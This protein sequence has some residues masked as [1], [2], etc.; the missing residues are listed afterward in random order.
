MYQL[1]IVAISV[2]SLLDFMEDIIAQNLS[3]KCERCGEPAYEKDGCTYALC[4]ECI[5]KDINRLM[6]GEDH[7]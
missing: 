5:N 7:D 3:A 2:I 6:F 4:V 1:R